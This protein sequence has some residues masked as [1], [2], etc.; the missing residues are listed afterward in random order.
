[1]FKAA[2]VVQ[3]RDL[4][5]E[6]IS[7]AMARP[8][9]SG[10]ERGSISPLRKVP[11]GWSSWETELRW[12][13]DVH[14]GTEGLSTAIESLGLPTAE[15]AGALAAQGCEVVISVRQDLVDDPA[16]VGLYLTPEAVSLLATAGAA[17]SV[18]QYVVSDVEAH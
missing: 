3:S 17:V 4:S 9:D 8:H 6:E 5:L 12:P 7:A 15:R 18:D 2:L 10:Y 13:D 14:A 11:R 1:M 16:S